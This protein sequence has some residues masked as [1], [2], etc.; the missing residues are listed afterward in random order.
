MGIAQLPP[1]GGIAAPL[2]SPAGPADVFR[3][4]PRTYAPRFDRRS[5]RSRVL[6]SSGYLTGGYAPYYPGAEYPYADTVDRPEASDFGY[7]RLNVQPYSA[8]V[9]V[10]GF[11]VST[12]GDFSGTAPARAIQAGPHRVEIR[13]DG[14]ETATFDVRIAPN[15]TITYRRELA[16]ADDVPQQARNI[17]PAA[18]KTFYVIPKCYAGDKRPSADRLP[19][20]CRASN[21]RAIPPVV[22]RAK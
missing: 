1:M 14:Y 6:D 18:P 10:D 11:Y 20:G 16:K 21:V 7:L 17:P 4:G 22:N 2:L 5:N 15:E 19:A 12:V 3:A 9:Y 13:A 8:Q